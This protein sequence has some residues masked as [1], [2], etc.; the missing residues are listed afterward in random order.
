MRYS[1]P[2]PHPNLRLRHRTRCCCP[3]T[4]WWRLLQTASRPGIVR[5]RER[6]KKIARIENTLKEMQQAHK[7]ATEAIADLRV[8]G[9][10]V[11]SIRRSLFC[12]SVVSRSY[13][14][15]SNFSLFDFSTP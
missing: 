14:A 6:C 5:R 10:P 3:Q 12:R 13:P 2:N 9:C 15:H 4:T 1:I 8:S 11:A 7:E